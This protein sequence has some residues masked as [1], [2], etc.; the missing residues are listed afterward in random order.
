MALTQSAWTSKTVNGHFVATATCIGG[1]ATD[2]YPSAAILPTNIDTNRPYTIVVTTGED[3]TAAGTT[4]VNLYT[5][6]ADS[7]SVAGDGTATSCYIGASVTNDLDAGATGVIHVLPAV[8]GNVTQVTNAS[9]A[10]VLLPAARV[11]VS[12]KT[13]ADLQAAPATVT[14]TVIQ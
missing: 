10:Y 12:A 5:C 2:R 11:I 3:M 4:T 13:S 9:P 1:A 14:Y 8:N 7:A 6:T